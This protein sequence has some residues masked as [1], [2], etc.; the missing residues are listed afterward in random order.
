M[1][2]QIHSALATLHHLAE[3]WGAL[4]LFAIV[5]LESVGAP[6][7]GESGVI[8]ASLL[9]LQ[10]ELSIIH[11]VLAAFLGAIVGDSIGFLIGR[12]YGT[13]VLDRFGHLVGLTPERRRDFEAR[14]QTHGTYVV[15][16]ARF[17]VV[18]RQ[19]NGLLAGANRMPYRRFLAADLVGSAAWTAVWGLGPYFFAE[20]FK[21]LSH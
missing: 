20:L 5:A 13:A 8:A 19:L 3:S 6:V 12:R 16:T 21:G 15:A 14:Y 1:Y 4:A 11:V 10:G 2:D 18:L 7:P 17:V 9:A